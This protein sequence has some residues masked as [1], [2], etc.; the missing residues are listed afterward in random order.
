MGSQSVCSDLRRRS[1]GSHSS[2]PAI[3]TE[4][5]SVAESTGSS[6]YSE[7]GS[8]PPPRLKPWS[9]DS[10]PSAPISRFSQPRRVA[11]P[12][13]AS[14]SSSIA[15]KCERFGAGSPVPCTAASRPASQSGSNGASSGCRPNV[16]SRA[17][18][19]SA[20]TAI[21]GRAW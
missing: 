11:E 15:A 1:L 13:S 9:G 7:V 18:S 4:D 5:T 14:S 6:P 3:P 8:T 10:W 21:C 17:S 12:G 20:G 2:S 16:P 19:R